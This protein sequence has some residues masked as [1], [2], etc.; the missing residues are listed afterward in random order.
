VTYYYDGADVGSITTGIT[1]SPIYVIVNNAI[2]NSQMPVVPADV[3]VDY[4]RVWQ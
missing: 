1:G 2:Q 3:Q 4:V